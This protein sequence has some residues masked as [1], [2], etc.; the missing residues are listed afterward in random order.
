[1]H[2]GFGAKYL[3]YGLIEERDNSDLYLGD[4]RPM[5]L[6]MT[7]NYG[8]RLEASHYLGVNISYIYEKLNTASSWGG[9]A[10]VGYIYKTPL[11]G[12]NT[13]ITFKHLGA[14]SKM[15]DE[16]IDL[17]MTAEAGITN[18]LEFEQIVVTTDM[19][20]VKEFKNDYRAA[21][22]VESSYA[23][24]LFLRAGYK[25]NFDEE[26]FSFGAG[27]KLEKM[28]IDYAFIPYEEAFGSVNMLSISYKF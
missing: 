27:I 24:L 11:K 22:G 23:G 20:A 18:L 1:M 16:S 14:T 12:T 3:D 25:F 15:E 8:I 6:Q 21:L 10:D 2:I 4:Y 26:E 17:P 5:D 13:Y 19:R 9:T 7:M 28:G